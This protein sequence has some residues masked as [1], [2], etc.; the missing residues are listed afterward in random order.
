MADATIT[1]PQRDYDLVAVAAV[2]TSFASLSITS[3]PTSGLIY[4]SKAS[5]GNSSPSLLRCIPWCDSA[6]ASATA[7]MRFIAWNRIEA[8]EGIR[9]IPTILGEF[10]TTYGNTLGNI[11]SWTLDG[12]TVRP[13]QTL[14]QVSN[15][16]NAYLYSPGSANV[17]A[18][19]ACEVLIDAKGSQF[20]TVQFAN[21]AAVSSTM[22]V[23]WTTI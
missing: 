9:W 5:T 4:S 3:A 22:G 7:S 18:A 1:T 6:S 14:S 10:T 16:P 12:Y 23:L 15:A 8:T 20:V 13:Y 11:P 2:P 21:S 17:A 19:E